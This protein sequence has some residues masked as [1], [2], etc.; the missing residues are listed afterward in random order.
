MKKTKTGNTY[1]VV[2]ALLIVFALAIAF[3]MP[4]FAEWSGGHDA[5]GS[6]RTSRTW[7]F[8]EGTTRAGFSEWICLF[9][10][11]G[12]PTNAVCSYMLATGQD[13]EK[14]YGLPPESRT[15][16]NVS[17]EVPPENDVSLV[18]I[19]EDPIVA[20]R[21]VYFTYKGAWPGGH[22]VVG[23]ISPSETWY[24][25]EGSTRDNFETYL[26]LAN[27]GDVDAVLNVY[28]Y[29]AD[30]ND[31]IK[32]GVVVARKSRFTIPV[33]EGELGIG[34]SNTAHGDFSIR[35]ESTNGVP[36]VAERSMYF[37][38]K[39]AW[40]GGHD[41]VGATE[42]R[43]TWYFAEGC[44][45]DGFD[46]Y[47]CLEN[48]SDRGTTANVYYYCADGNNEART[49]IALPAQSRFTIPVHEGGLGIGRH[50][51][52]HGDFSIKVESAG[53]IP[54]V[55]ERSMYFS[56]RPSWTGGHDVVGAT[57]PADLWYFAEGCT[58]DGFETYLCVENPSDRGTTAN[59]YYYCADGRNEER[60]GI[61][62]AAQSR[63]TIPVH[64]TAFGI[65]RHN[66]SHGDFSIRVESTGN[67]PVVA[68][69]SMYFSSPWRTVDRA[70]LAAACGWGEV[71]RANTSKR[72]IALTFD[73]ESSGG[74]ANSILD[75]LKQK[76]VHSTLFVTGGFPGT[77]PGVVQRMAAEGHEIANHSM[78]HAMFTRISG[79]QV[80][81]EL[82]GTEAAVRQA[83]GYSTKP[84][85]RFPYGDRNGALI[86]QVNAEGYLSVYWT[87]DPQE[88]RSGASA[89]GVRATVVSQACNG[90]IVL[91]HD[92]ATTVAALPGIIDDLR[93]RGYSL[94]T[95]TEALY[96]GP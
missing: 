14:S 30:G 35:V 18:I 26:C 70:S 31:E 8:A 55:A 71:S 48:P 74:L 57:K 43:G 20:E 44:T 3:P 21:P 95:L 64:E 19:S 37:S 38:Y 11:G 5:M 58:R 75:I 2:A 15:T 52:A 84:Y 87:I 7:Y 24:F 29:C 69:R 96:P 23:A 72:C 16:I 73:I 36:V 78:S 1:G 90:A 61:N 53:G 93:A 17:T 41:V 79:A 65:G 80:S 12:R 56:Y 39:G 45:R 66:N 49:G 91:M 40:S 83:T 28:Y 42:P 13:I 22:D 47:L 76:S 6:P 88:W 77:Y 9:N 81:S 92:R 63:L 94:V 85:F 68:E 50:D 27:P 10:P 4:A 33:H 46:T 82:A 25:A 51:N 67:I 89:E 59:V 34:R 86:R 54:I 32:T 60:K 62:V